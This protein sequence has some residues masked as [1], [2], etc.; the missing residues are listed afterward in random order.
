[1]F[2]RSILAAACAILSGLTAL[3]D[4]ATPVAVR[5]QA[6]LSSG[7]TLLTLDRAAIARAASGVR[8]IRFESLPLGDE[9]VDLSLEPFRVLAPDATIM[10]VDEAGERSADFDPASVSFWRGSVDGAHGSHVFLSVADGSV[11]GRIELGA[12]QPTF[13]ISSEGG[14]L[15]AGGVALDEGQVVVFRAN[16]SGYRETAP[17]ACGVG[18]T[19][20]GPPGELP[21]P[22][23]NGPATMPT[24][25]VGTP[26]LGEHGRPGDAVWTLL[27]H[28]DRSSHPRPSGRTPRTVQ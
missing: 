2:R 10:V 26:V 25:A 3:A 20:I 7:H 22:S 17:I 16:A 27:E 23:T 4:P 15:D 19:P 11:V 12:G 6:E 24:P 14:D 9:L 8:Q 13:A 21:P 18:I 5:A 28:K 1:M